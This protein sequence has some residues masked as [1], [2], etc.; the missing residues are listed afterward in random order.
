[1]KLIHKDCDE[2]LGKDKSLPRDSYIVTYLHNEDVKYDIVQ[3]SSFVEVFDSYYD[4]LGKDSIKE[5]KW[6]DGTVNPKV[7][8]EKP[9]GKRK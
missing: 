2:S 7:Y 6:T 5:I 3:A 8:G 4:N 1:M 9:K